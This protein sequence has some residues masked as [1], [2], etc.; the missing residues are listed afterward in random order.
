MS[1]QTTLK[2]Y[3]KVLQAIKLKM[4]GVVSRDTICS[5]ISC[6]KKFNLKVCTC[7]TTLKCRFQRNNSSD[8]YGSHL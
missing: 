5:D 1:L 8:L 2:I 7:G 3:E 4:S 6:E